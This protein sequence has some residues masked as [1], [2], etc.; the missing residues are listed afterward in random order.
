LAALGL[1]LAVAAAW[2]AR[3]GNA[4][5]DAGYALALALG[6]ALPV[7]VGLFAWDGAHSRFARGL[8]VL[9]L[10]SFVPALSGSSDAVLYSL[11]R[12]GAWCV[13]VASAC[14]VLAF[15][16]GRLTDR[17][18]RMLAW[19]AVGLVLGLYVPSVLLVADYPVPAPWAA[20]VNDCP[21]NAF[22]LASSQPA[23]VD[24]FLIPLREI[25]SIALLVAIPLRLGLRIRGA[26]RLMRR[27]LVP[28][29]VASI[30]ATVG[31]AIGFQVRRGDPTSPL[32]GPLMAL[33]VLW[34]PAVSIGL[35]VGVVR[36][37]FYVAGAL[38]RL[39]VGVRER[40]GP[41]DLEVL[42]AG[43]LDD[44][45]AQLAYRDGAGQ[46]C[47]VRGRPLTV[48]ADR[49]VTEIRDADGAPGAVVH[50]AGLTHERP[51]VEAVAAYALI[52][53][54][55]H[56]MAAEVEASL[57]KLAETRASAVAAADAERRRIERDIHDGTQQRLVAFGVRLT[58][59]EELMDDDP[60][61][62]RAMIRGLKGELDDALDEVRSLAAGIYPAVLADFGLAEALPA[63][64]RRA[65]AP[66][67]V[68]VATT[69]RF[70]TDVE[71]TVYFC[72]SEALQNAAKHAPGASVS[73]SVRRSGRALAFRV[74]DD[75]PGFEPS[76]ATDGHG[77]ANMR[78][79]LEAVGGT[80]AIVGSPGKGACV[81]GN[82]PLPGRAAV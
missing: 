58:L 43:V 80:L 64:A 63:L 29:L 65:P 49:H 62:A 10:F 55:N 17:V 48:G 23:F 13:I 9:G 25:L 44:P 47:D 70:S 1:G 28:V 68:D 40:V 53:E 21:P 4:P 61:R 78:G 14:L 72:C 75:G 69:E 45:T 24:A 27:T 76:Q 50:D 46:W 11:G 51:F 6:V 56:R 73:I 5:D 36:W 59:A 82:I 39:S 38:Q 79:R 16:S 20:C 30:C 67:R 41:Q 71:T 37:R 15:P 52:G 34:L 32:L 74:C 42:A 2:I 12:A 57:R 18:D 66:V 35:G 33:I 22:M 26:T 77:L 7:G 81:N 60:A 3:H 19:G 31:L 54:Q 8:V